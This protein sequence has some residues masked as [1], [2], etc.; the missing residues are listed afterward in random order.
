MKGDIAEISIDQLARLARDAGM[1]ARQELPSTLRPAV[2][3]RGADD[4]SF[5]PF[6][7]GAVRRILGL[8]GVNNKERDT[9]LSR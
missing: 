1:S 6:D 4:S 9:G 5:Y 2:P 8:I 3:E 7:R